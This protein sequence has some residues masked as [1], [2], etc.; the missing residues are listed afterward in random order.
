ML[1]AIPQEYLHDYDRKALRDLKEIPAFDKICSKFVQLFDE[2]TSYMTDM[3]SKVRL[4]EEQL[5]RIYNMLPDIC[6]KLGID[7]IPPLYLEMDRTPNA[8]TYGDK[9]PSITITSGLLECLNDEEIYSILAHECGHIACKHVL[10]HTIGKLILNDGLEL[11]GGGSFITA[12]VAL[13]LKLAFFNWMRCSDFSADRAAAICCGKAEPVVQTMTRLA[14]GTS[15][16]TDE[17][18]R[19]LFIAQAA[20]YEQIRNKSKL[21]KFVEFAVISNQTHSLLSVRAYEITKWIESD[22][23]KAIL[24]HLNEQEDKNSETPTVKKCPNCNT[25]LS[26][27]AIFCQ[28]CGNKY[29]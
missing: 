15:H 22:Q 5:P 20:D 11:L 26:E 14:G 10:Y 18:N 29:K 1:P 28:I 23:Y 4:S 9:K 27:K 21:N 7:T 3:A 2:K 24:S 13:S 25:D 19:D 6:K 16:I 8:Y 12:A 17:I